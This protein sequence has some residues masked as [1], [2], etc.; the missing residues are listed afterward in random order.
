MLYTFHCIN[1]MYSSNNRSLS[2]LSFVTRKCCIGII[3]QGY[4]QPESGTWP[5]N[6]SGPIPGK[7]HLMGSLKSVH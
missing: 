3:N 4:M 5:R 6:L 1:L 2:G 7:V